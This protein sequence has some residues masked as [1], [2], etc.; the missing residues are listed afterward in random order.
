MQPKGLGFVAIPE[1]HPGEVLLGKVFFDRL[2]KTLDI[3]G[4]EGLVRKN[5]FPD[6]YRRRL[7]HKSFNPLVYCKCA[8]RIVTCEAKIE[9]KSTTATR[10]RPV[11][12][13]Q[14]TST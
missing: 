8:N 7:N 10:Q 4:A 5:D 11:Y 9:R 1:R 6:V 3:L 12:Q 14:R 2:G 13:S